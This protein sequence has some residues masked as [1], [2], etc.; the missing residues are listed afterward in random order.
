[1]FI[2]KMFFGI[3]R[4]IA[5]IFTRSRMMQDF[6]GFILMIAAIGG[7]AFWFFTQ[8]P[9][10][11]P[12]PI[13]EVIRKIPG[14]EYFK[15]FTHKPDTDT[16]TTTNNTT[17]D[18]NDE[19]TE[20]ENT[21][22]DV[23]GIDAEKKTDFVLPHYKIPGQ[24][25]R[26]KG[27]TL[28]YSDKYKQPVFVA[29]KLTSAMTQGSADRDNDTFHPDSKVETSR[30]TPDEYLGTGYDRGHLA[31]AADFKYSDDA[32]N[33]T[34]VMSNMSPQAPDC[35]REI[36]RICEEQT[37]AWAKK[38]KSVYVVSGPELKAGLKTIGKKHRIAVPERYFKIILDLHQP[39][40]KAIAFIIPNSGTTQPLKSFVVSI[41]E[42]EKM[43]GLDFFP[44][45][46]ANLKTELKNQ[47][48]PAD[49]TWQKARKLKN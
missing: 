24:L 36:W 16:H 20:T 44:S 9:D 7:V 4:S 25:I 48:N 37:R 21:T 23:N 10:L 30:V 40:P 11:T 35:N 34:F 22:E 42:V 31:P 12:D 19:T 33:D 46:P 15:K 1:M 14:F 47:S 3:F 13:A 26:H 8:N 49:W 43:T 29:Y 32:M 28:Y 27:Y 39:K 41:A 18:T 5:S 38:Y 2:F 17:T 45:L 6:I